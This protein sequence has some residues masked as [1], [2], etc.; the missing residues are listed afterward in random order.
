MSDHDHLD[1]AQLDWGDIV[2]A[3]ARL[4]NAGI[5]LPDLSLAQIL[6][7]PLGPTPDCLSANEVA[8]HIARNVAYDPHSSQ[9]AHVTAC[10][11]C[12]DALHTFRSIDPPRRRATRIEVEPTIKIPLPTAQ[13]QIKV[14]NFGDSRVLTTIDPGSVVVQSPL[15]RACDGKVVQPIHPPNGASE[16]TVITFRDVKCKLVPGETVEEVPITFSGYTVSG[17]F[18]QGRNFTKLVGV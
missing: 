16:A 9:A 6:D 5:G 3:R 10:S 1:P 2:R 13:L 8:E 4:R 14:A 12:L 18:I 7:E 15:F 11:S 17:Q